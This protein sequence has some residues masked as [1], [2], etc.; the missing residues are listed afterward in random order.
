VWVILDGFAGHV[1]SI[2]GDHGR[3]QIHVETVGH[4]YTVGSPLHVAEE[5]I[6]A[7]P[8]DNSGPAAAE[9]VGGRQI[10]FTETQIFFPGYSYSL[11]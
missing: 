4:G 8:S 1:P 2:R 6:A 10:N 3:L 11:S 5:A 7:R 9:V